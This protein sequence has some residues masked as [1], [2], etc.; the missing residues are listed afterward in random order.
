M[1]AIVQL[2][3]LRDIPHIESIVFK[4]VTK[5]AY[6]PKVMYQIFLKLA[7]GETLVGRDKYFPRH[8]ITTIIQMNNLRALISAEKMGLLDKS[9]YD[10]LDIVTAWDATKSN[11]LEILK[12]VRLHG[13]PWDKKVCSIAAKKGNLKML[14]WAR[15]NGC[16]CDKLV[17]ERAA[18]FGHLDV[19]KWAWEHNCPMDEWTFVEA[20]SH[21]HLYILEWLHEINAKW[22]NQASILADENNHYDVTE[23]L[24]KHGY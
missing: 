13:C 1:V 23:W 15:E 8:F 10:V 22:N 21:G 20:A 14:I 4:L 7:N 2:D 5:Y 12:F 17:C 9:K 24:W 6:I 16:E 3:F 19:L 11:N 18:T